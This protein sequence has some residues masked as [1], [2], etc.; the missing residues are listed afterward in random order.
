MARIEAQLEQFS[1]AEKE[2]LSLQSEAE[3][4]T[5]LE[6]EQTILQK[7]V[8]DFSNIHFQQQNLTAQLKS[9]NADIARVEADLK[10]LAALQQTTQKIPQWEESTE[11]AATAAEP[12]GSGSTV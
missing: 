5:R 1:V 3:I 12:N 4:Q 9:T 8:Q 11:S 10:R 6:S 2:L 7:K